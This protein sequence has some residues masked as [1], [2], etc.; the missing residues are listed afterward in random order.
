[1]KDS[2]STRYDE[3]L[4][5]HLEEGMPDEDAKTKAHNSLL[6]IYR[7]S[8]FC[9]LASRARALKFDPMNEEF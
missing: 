4:E 6:P 5:C 1:M 8:T 7:T 3:Q 9:T 2:S